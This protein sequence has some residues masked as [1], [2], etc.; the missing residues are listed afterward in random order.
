MTTPD[1]T[2]DLPA[3]KRCPH[4]GETKPRGGFNVNNRAKSGLSSWCKA[5]ISDRYKSDPDRVKQKSRDW[6][7]KNKQRALE[8]NHEYRQAHEAE[9]REMD[10]KYRERNAE[11]II[12][13]QR[14][15]RQSHRDEI[16]LYRK[17]NAERIKS[18]ER[19]YQKTHRD[20][21]AAY[22]AEYRKEYFRSEHGKAVK[23]SAEH[24]RRARKLAVGGTFN[25]QDIEALRIGQT[26][27]AG[28]LHCWWCGSV[29]TRWHI[30]HRIPLAR[31]G[32]NNAS[33]LCL[34]CPKCNLSKRAKMPT[35]IGRLI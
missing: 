12:E 6:Y 19:E 14:I 15:Y 18:K 17:V 25:R 13:Q 3:F 10:R 7:S 8:R 4:C 11:R 29:I 31:G 16:R 28:R 33:N 35:E 27:K 20:E 5:C 9:K 23:A 2:P 1:Y 22:R 24:R 26:D 32:S 21:I 34:A 30:D